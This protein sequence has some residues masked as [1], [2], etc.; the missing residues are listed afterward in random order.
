MKIFDAEVVS[1][2][3][4]RWKNTKD[5]NILQQILVET[6]DLARHIA[7][8]YTSA[9][10]DDF[11]QEAL[12]KVMSSLEHYNSSIS[13]IHTYFS[14]VIRNSCITQY[15]KAKTCDSIESD[16]IQDVENSERMQVNDVDTSEESCYID[17]LIDRN[18]SRFPSLS[19]EIITQSTKLIYCLT[20][21]G[22]HNKS[23]GVVSA[24]VNTYNMSRT[25]AKIVYRSTIIHMRME[26]LSNASTTISMKN[27]E[28]S[29]LPELRE[30]LGDD[31][32]ARFLCTF[33]GTTINI[34]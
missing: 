18:I 17:E 28:M 25:L 10:V 5:Q 1:E 33:T 22:T 12:I 24:L 3:V 19:S 23:R 31:T 26:L 2:L 6:N 34:K 14:T 15:A 29:I 32:Y 30:F 4:I 13:N 21:D 16:S 9:E 20:R 8:G 7:N 11:S 27:Q